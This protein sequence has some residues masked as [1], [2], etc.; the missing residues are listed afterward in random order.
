MLDNLVFQ[1]VT[2]EFKERG[3]GG[4]SFGPL[5]TGQKLVDFIALFNRADISVLET[6]MEPAGVTSIS[7]IEPSEE[8]EEKG[9]RPFTTSL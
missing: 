7:L 8:D 1:F 6:E 3:I 2:D 5:L 4:I 9:R